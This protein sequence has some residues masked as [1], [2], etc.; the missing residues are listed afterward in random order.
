MKKQTLVVI[1]KEI[2]EQDAVLV[3][4][5][6]QE[7]RWPKGSLPEDVKIGERLIINLSRES[8][9]ES[10]ESPREF[11]NSIISPNR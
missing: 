5:D 6:G 3:A 7:I 10:I 4:P 8:E 9:A 1:L 2:N 11:L